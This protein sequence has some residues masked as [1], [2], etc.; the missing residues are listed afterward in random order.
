[1]GLMQEP[2]VAR[3]SD[4]REFAAFTSVLIHNFLLGTNEIQQNL[5]YESCKES[6][7]LSPDLRIIM[8]SSEWIWS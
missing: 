1:M 7:F 2:K 4:L 6:L 3:T 5:L 8:Y